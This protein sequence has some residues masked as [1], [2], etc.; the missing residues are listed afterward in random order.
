MQHINSQENKIRSTID[1]FRFFVELFQVILQ[2]LGFDRISAQ[3]FSMT[4]RSG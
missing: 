3:A 1:I 2:N 4:S